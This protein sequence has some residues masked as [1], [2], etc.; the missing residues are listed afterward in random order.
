MLT[1]S[2]LGY[3]VGPDDAQVA[4]PR[5]TYGRQTDLAALHTLAHNVTTGLMGMGVIHFE[6]EDVTMCVATLH[7]S[8]LFLGHGT[9]CNKSGPT[10]METLQDV[11][12]HCLNQTFV[13][14]IKGL[15]E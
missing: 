3:L 7:N 15:I 14:Y 4:R 12:L 8:L 6:G 5:L 11:F 1:W 10:I 9:P 2:I 13:N